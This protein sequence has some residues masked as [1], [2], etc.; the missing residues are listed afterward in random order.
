VQASDVKSGDVFYNGSRTQQTGTYQSPGVCPTQQYTDY[1]GSPVT[2][3]TNCSQTWTTASP[4]VTGDDK[5]DPISGL[6]WSLNIT[7]NDGT[8]AFSTTAFWDWSWDGTSTS[9][10]IAVGGKTAVQLCSGMDGGGIWRLP[11]QKELMQAYIDGSYFNLTNPSSDY[12][13]STIMY[14]GSAFYVNLGVGYAVT[15]PYSSGLS[16]RCVR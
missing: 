10:S 14:S 15:Q 1:Y 2:P 3:T 16:V 9:D 11:S 4:T 8:P 7:N 6:V 12:W 5:Q 13:S